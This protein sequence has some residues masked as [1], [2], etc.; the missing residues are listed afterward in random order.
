MKLPWE[1]ALG[2]QAF[3]ALFFWER[4]ITSLVVRPAQTGRCPTVHRGTR[5]C[6]VGGSGVLLHLLFVKNKKIENECVHVCTVGSKGNAT[7][8]RS[9]K[10]GFFPAVP[11]QGVIR[12]DHGGRRP[13]AAAWPLARCNLRRSLYPCSEGG[14]DVS[15]CNLILQTERNGRKRKKMLDSLD[16]RMKP[17]SFFREG[18]GGTM[19]VCAYFRYLSKAQYHG[20]GTPL[21]ARTEPCG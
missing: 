4:I 6:V 5:G 18:R 16:L 3:G 19:S 21:T 17:F 13:S 10:K 1:G 7:A 8:N 9:E 12:S 15:F 2:P 20:T 14:F 11:I